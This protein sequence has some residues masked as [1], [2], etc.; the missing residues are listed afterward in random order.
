MKTLVCVILVVVGTTALFAS[1][2]MQWRHYSQGRRLVLNALDMSFRHQSFP[3]EHGPLSGADLT[4]VKKSMQSME[5]SYSRVHGLVPA[6]I[7][8][9]AFWYCVGPGPSWFL[10][11]PVVTAGFGRVEVQWIVRPLTEQLMRISLQSGRKAFQRAF[12]DSAARA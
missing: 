9:D 4:V 12:G 1:V 2:L 11:I 7:T 3:G 8:A 6:V 5:A 10:A